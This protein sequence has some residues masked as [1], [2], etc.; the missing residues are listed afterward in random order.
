MHKTLQDHLTNTKRS[1]VLLLYPSVFV[2]NL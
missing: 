1:C 2:S